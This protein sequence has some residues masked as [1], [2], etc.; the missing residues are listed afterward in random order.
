MVSEF[1]VYKLSTWTSVH[2][3]KEALFWGRWRNTT[4]PICGGERGCVILD[5]YFQKITDILTKNLV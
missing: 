2:G 1:T 4:I 3:S 5:R